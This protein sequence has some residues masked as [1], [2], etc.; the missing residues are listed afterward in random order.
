MAGGEWPKASLYSWEGLPSLGEPFPGLGKG[1]SNLWE[2]T[3]QV[4][5]K[6]FPT[7]GKGSPSLGEPFPSLGKALPRSWERVPQPLRKGPQPLGTASQVLGKGL[8]TFG[9]D[10]PALNE[11]LPNLGERVNT[12]PSPK[13]SLREVFFCPE[14]VSN[15]VSE[16]ASAEKHRPH[17]QSLPQF[18]GR[19][20]QFPPLPVLGEGG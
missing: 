13:M 7:F 17:P 5:G 10:S 9:K 8:P 16:I 2:S 12:Q 19:G 20:V 6:G 14:A 4:S 1:L 11:R 18:W 15:M 3:P